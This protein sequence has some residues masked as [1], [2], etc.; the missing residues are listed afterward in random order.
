[1]WSVNTIFMINSSRLWKHSSNK[2]FSLCIIYTT[3]L[4]IVPYQPNLLLYALTAFAVHYA[5]CKSQLNHKSSTYKICL[6]LNL[7]HTNCRLLLVLF[8]IFSLTKL[9]WIIPVIHINIKGRPCISSSSWFI[10]P[11]KRGSPIQA[12]LWKKHFFKINKKIS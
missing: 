3:L 8:V 10:H 4:K 2:Y 5:Y 1:M 11:L 12:C 7:T 9:W 6:D